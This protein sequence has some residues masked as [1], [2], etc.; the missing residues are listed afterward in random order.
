MPTILLGTSSHLTHPRRPGRLMRPGRP[1]QTGN[2]SGAG[3]GLVPDRLL[4]GLGSLAGVGDEVREAA[5]MRSARSMTL[6][7]DEAQWIGRTPRQKTA[8]HVSSTKRRW[9]ADS[10]HL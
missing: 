10:Y 4:P 6:E 7:A 3:P 1:G 5:L 9:R 2:S 8:R